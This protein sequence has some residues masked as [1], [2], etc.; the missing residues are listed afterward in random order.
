MPYTRPINRAR[1]Q[2]VQEC[3]LKKQ[4]SSSGSQVVEKRWGVRAF[5]WAGRRRL[6][7]KNIKRTQ[8][9]IERR[10]KKQVKRIEKRNQAWSIWG[11]IEE[12]RGEGSDGAWPLGLGLVKKVRNHLSLDFHNSGA[13]RCEKGG[14]K[15]KKKDTRKEESIQ[16]KGVGSS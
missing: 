4:T 1:F 14:E 2:D 11:K 10:E 3:Y 8:P 5:P 7:E 13:A 16:R 12:K 15:G 9:L 6:T